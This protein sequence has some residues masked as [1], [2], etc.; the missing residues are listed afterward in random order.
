MSEK[1]TLKL[2]GFEIVITHGSEYNN[3]TACTIVSLEFHFCHFNFFILPNFNR[4]CLL[5]FWFSKFFHAP[6]MN[7]LKWHKR[8]HI[9]RPFLVTVQ[10][11]FKGSTRASTKNTSCKFAKILVLADPGEGF[12]LSWKEGHLKILSGNLRCSWE[13]E[14]E[15]TEKGET[16]NT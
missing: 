7:V 9:N 5:F 15:R 1:L 10:Q 8:K 2:K 13:Q 16:P 12:Q 14:Q 6:M 3:W 11:I 4:A